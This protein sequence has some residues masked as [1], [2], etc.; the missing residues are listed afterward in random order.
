MAATILRHIH[1]FVFGA[2]LMVMQGC[3][4]ESDNT[5]TESAVTSPPLI[6]PE[7]KENSVIPITYKTLYQQPFLGIGG[8]WD[9]YSYTNNS[10]SE[11]DFNTIKARVSW[12][13]PGLVRIMILTQWYYNNGHYNWDSPA[14]QQLYRVLDYCQTQNITVILTDWGVGTPGQPE[15][16]WLKTPGIESITD[17]NYASAIS[18]SLNYLIH[19]KGYNTI[20]YF[21]MGNEPNLE[22]VDWNSWKEALLQTKIALD[23]LMQSTDL[24]LMGSDESGDPRWHEGAVDYLHDTLGAYDYHGYPDDTLVR[25]G[26]VEALVLAKNQ[27]VLTNDPAG[28]SKPVVLTEAGVTPLTLMDEFD[29]GVKMADFAIQA[30]NAGISGISA[31]M[32]DDNSYPGFNNGMWRNSDQGLTVRPWYYLWATLSRSVPK[33]SYIFNVTSTEPLFRLTAAQLPESGWTIAAVNRSTAPIRFSLQ[34]PES[35]TRQFSHYLYSEGIYKLSNSSLPLP[36][37][38]IDYDLA[39]PIAYTLPGNSALVITTVLP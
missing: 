33:G 34:L 32:L 29:Y 5:S 22:V 27:Y 6:A 25:E 3:S 19:T 26:A 15:R 11:D 4:S 36:T 16:D 2:L 7:S 18:A 37:E 39:T 21:V 12:M 14:M 30:M 10:P 13:R 8:E 20:R 24:T 23:S 1:F 28:A 38:T 35:N 9:T 17:P 31:W